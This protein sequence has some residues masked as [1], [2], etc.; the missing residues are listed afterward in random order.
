MPPNNI[1]YWDSC[2][3]IA[4][5][6]DEK[7]PGNEMDGVYE[8]VEETE[9]NRTFIITSVLTK[10]E[11]L[12]A[13]LILEAKDKYQRL[14]SRRNVQLIDNDLRVSN[15]AG[16]IREYYKNIKKHDGLPGLTTPDAVHLAT[17]IHYRAHFFWTFDNGG[18]GSRSLLS[19]S[20][21]VAGYPLVICKPA[22]T[23]LRLSF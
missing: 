17:A 18:Y 20:G 21:N 22:A 6:K 14:L 11:V 7:R 3:F 15:L 23:Q 13:D 8:C 12:E 9:R 1:I 19:L 10:T 5:L 2:I 4:W 16:E